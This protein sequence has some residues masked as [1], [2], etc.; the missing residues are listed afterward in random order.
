MKD[1]I[2]Q[3]I[4]LILVLSFSFYYTDKA[5]TIARKNDPIMIQI[6][7]IK[8]ELKVDMID[9]MINKDEYVSGINGCEIDEQMSYTKMKEAG[10]FDSNL[11]VMKEDKIKRD[12]KGKYII[13]GNKIQ[14]KVS[15]IF[16][17]DEYLDNK[18]LDILKNKQENYN[19]FVD[20]KLLEEKLIEIKKL[21]TLGSIY[22]L[23]RNNHY[24]D[25][26]I[27]YD[28]NLIE[29]ISKNKSN[30]CLLSKKNK[31]DLN[32]CNNFDMNMIKT[33][34]ISNDIFETTKKELEN[35]KIFTYKKIN[36]NIN[37]IIV[38]LNYIKSKG[39]DIVL[40]DELLNENNDCKY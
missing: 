35:G 32:L 6:N 33:N 39:Y 34:Y 27:I 15:I 7:N 25:K 4:V 14:K 10:R 29:T 36:N 37:E 1:K 2:M 5:V 28:N 8:E 24:D 18:I 21:K 31:H 16:I 22:N 13:G 26:F 30:Y 11:L 19:F 23:G 9:P 20:G 17:V 38:A 3:I 12:K 40:L